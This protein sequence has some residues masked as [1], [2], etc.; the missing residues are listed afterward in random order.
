MR[1][2][3]GSE[4]LTDPV[5]GKSV[6]AH[7]P[8]RIVH[9][10]SLFCFCSGRCR[11]VFSADPEHFA[12]IAQAEAARK[13]SSA[14]LSDREAAPAPVQPA[15][16]AFEPAPPLAA[17]P[18]PSEPIIDD[19]EP[20]PRTETIL[21]LP[22]S[23]PHASVAPGPPPE[24]G[25][26]DRLVALLPGREQRFVRR[27]SRELLDLYRSVSAA[28]ARLRGRDLYRQV[29][30]ARKRANPKSADRL[31]DQAEESYAMWPA[32]RALT[33][34]DVVHFIAV[35]EFLASHGDTPWLHENVRREVESLIPRDL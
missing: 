14:A 22:V 9:G 24:A 18:P 6:D 5:C 17:S 29:V 11:D 4:A 2:I 26:R 19:W 16:P 3:G 1:E 21:K 13:A 32:P 20:T 7:S 30:I 23:Q 27:V 25:W 12:A 28:D 8:H 31:L 35:S 33:F 34:C 15:A 10:G